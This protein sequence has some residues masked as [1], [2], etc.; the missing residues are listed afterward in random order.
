M[1]DIVQGIMSVTTLWWCLI[2][3]VT[4]EHLSGSIFIERGG[5]KKQHGF[6]MAIGSSMQKC[7]YGLNDE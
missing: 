3:S 4:V 5:R 6:D 2:T 1:L 7:C